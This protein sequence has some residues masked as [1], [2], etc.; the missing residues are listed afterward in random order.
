M[1]NANRIARKINF[2]NRIITLDGQIINSGGSITGGAINKNNNSSI[3]H[4]AELDELSQNLV[5]INDKI[6]KL[7]SPLE[8]VTATSAK[9]FSFR[10]FSPRKDNIFHATT[11]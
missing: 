5:K 2:R 8:N 4:K 1:D 9:F 3:K 11:T 10:I 7:S 6:E